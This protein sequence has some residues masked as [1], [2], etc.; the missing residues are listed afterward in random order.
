VP[1]SLSWLAHTRPPASESNDEENIQV[2]DGD[3]RKYPVGPARV[4]TRYVP[5]MTHVQCSAEDALLCNGSGPRSDASN[6]LVPDN[7]DSPPTHRNSFQ[8]LC[9]RDQRQTESGLSFCRA[10]ISCSPMAVAV[11]SNSRS[12]KD[13]LCASNSLS[14]SARA[15]PAAPPSPAA[16]RRAA[17]IGRCPLISAGANQRAEGAWPALQVSKHHPEALGVHA[18]SAQAGREIPVSSR[19]SLSVC[20]RHLERGRLDRSLGSSGACLITTRKR[21]ASSPLVI[22]SP[23]KVLLEESGAYRE[24]WRVIPA[25][26]T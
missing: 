4:G 20:P 16:R 7:G 3:H 25:R 1:Q 26:D 18:K 17:T 19:P 22:S 11:A 10:S 5:A 8:T 21:Q 24:S 2:S 9:L 14:R 12:T 23:Y 13:P 6:S 15:G